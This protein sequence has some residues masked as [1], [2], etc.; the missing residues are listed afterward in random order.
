MHKESSK[1][2]VYHFKDLDDPRLDRKKQHKLIDIIVIAI[3]GI[4]CNADTWVDIQSF[5]EAKYNWLKQFLALENGIPSHDTFGRVFSIIDP[6]KFK[7]CFLNWINE[8]SSLLNKEIIAIDG[9]TVR[10]SH[11]RANNK[12]AIHI[13]S[14]WAQNSGIVIGQ[15]KVDEKSNEITAIPELLSLL[16]INNCIVTIDAMGC[17]KLIAEKIIDKGADY[18]LALKGNQGQLYEDVK[19]YFDGAFEIN[20]KDIK[21]DFHKTLDKDH[22]RIE[23]REYWITNEIE[24]M[25]EKKEWEELKTIGLV[26]STRII[27]DKKTTEMRFYIS[28]LIA[29]A[30]IFGNAVR[31][32]WAIENSLHWVLDL[33]FRE[34]ESRV[35]KDNAPENLASLR[36]IALNLIKQESTV[37]KSIK[38][39]RLKAGWDNDYLARV[40]FKGAQ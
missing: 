17:Q 16:A 27:G 15:V 9:K 24:W 26:K 14:A 7:K 39:K 20:F 13:V 21:Y 6:E 40:L 3:C 31:S 32:H 38:S 35:R 8:I 22:G 23:K 37:K 29:D 11:D 28:S 12:S 34:D 2:I 18:V 19:L 25:D 4:I 10:H 33:A 1:N 30:K 36:H 5:G